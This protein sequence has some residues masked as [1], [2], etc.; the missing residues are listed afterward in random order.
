MNSVPQDEATHPTSETRM[1]A[2]RPAK[3]RERTDGEKLVDQMRLQLS[4][5]AYNLEEIH[6]DELGDS[7]LGNL[8]QQVLTLMGMTHE[9]ED[10]ASTVDI[11]RSAARRRERKVEECRP[12]GAAFQREMNAFA[13]ELA[14]RENEPRAARSLLGQARNLLCN[15]I[16]LIGK[17]EAAVEVAS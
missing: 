5:V 12:L 17:L 1:K 7:H 14:A 16:F 10:I 4:L 2:A 13:R 15:A 9:V 11:L 8:R 6:G 3:K